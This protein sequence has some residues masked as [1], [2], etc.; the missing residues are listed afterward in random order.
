[1]ELGAGGA[2]NLLKMLMKG[3]KT[4]EICVWGGQMLLGLGW[5]CREGLYLLLVRADVCW[6]HLIFSEIS[7]FS[8]KRRLGLDESPVV[9]WE[10]RWVSSPCSNTVAEG[11]NK[12][13]CT[14]E[15]RA[16]STISLSIPQKM[17]TKSEG[18]ASH[19]QCFVLLRDLCALKPHFSLLHMLNEEDW[20]C[21]MCATP[22]T[23]SRG[24][25]T[26]SQLNSDFL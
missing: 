25:G 9:V 10:H 16:Y 22:C 11:R 7:G 15:I 20:S 23:L 4:Q 6:G 17:S 21:H 8:R 24:E 13:R 1:M 26:W 2:I 3:L 12:S 18:W 14:V 19:W 5:T